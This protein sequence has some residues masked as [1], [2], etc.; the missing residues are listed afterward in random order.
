MSTPL[1]LPRCLAM[2][3][4]HLPAGRSRFA[5][6]GDSANVGFAVQPLGVVQGIVFDDSNA[7]GILRK[8]RSRHSGRARHHGWRNH[9]RPPTS[10]VSAAF[11]SLAPDVY[12][13]AVTVPDGFTALSLTTYDVNIGATASG[14]ANFAPHTPETIS[15]RAFCRFQ[16]QRCL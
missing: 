10:M 14:F 8:R 15:G 3:S 5:S 6:A 13:V 9:P 7:N 16:Q 4:C 11:T 2:V 12:R 1:A